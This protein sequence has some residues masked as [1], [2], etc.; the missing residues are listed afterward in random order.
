M[1][2][3]TIETSELGP[4]I[5]TTAPDVCLQDHERYDRSLHSL[6][7][8]RGLLVGFITDIWVPASIR[9]ILFMQKY[10]R[11]FYDED[12]SL[13]LI[14]GDQPHTLY[15]FHLSSEIR[16]SV[17]MLADPGHAA[18][19]LFQMRHAGLVLID[20]EATI[21]AKWLIPDERVWMKPRQMLT[22]I[23]NILS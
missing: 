17:P 22:E 12:I 1:F 16:V 4:T 18:H 20:D 14:I 23:S 5:G 11:K 6:I 9:R 2:A 8:G 3:Q 21:R 7:H 10:Q 13:A 19:Q 15:S